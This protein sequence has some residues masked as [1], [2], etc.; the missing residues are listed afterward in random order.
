M[1]DFNEHVGT[2]TTKWKSVIK[3]HGVTGLNENGS[4]LL[5]HCSSNGL[6]IMNTF[7]QLKSVYK[8]TWYQPSMDQISLL[9]FSVLLFDLIFGVKRTPF[10]ISSKQPL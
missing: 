9:D 6:C 8:Y 7:F 10:S 1:G 3:K 5:H 2:E 4:Y